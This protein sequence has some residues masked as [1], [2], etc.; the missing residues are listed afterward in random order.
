MLYVYVKPIEQ[1]EH[2]NFS[3]LYRCAFLSTR[4]FW[5]L[6]LVNVDTLQQFFLLSEY[7]VPSG[8]VAW[9]C[10]IGVSNW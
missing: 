9:W 2:V 8:T 6:V 1:F 5:H 4:Y 7:I 10:T 3:A